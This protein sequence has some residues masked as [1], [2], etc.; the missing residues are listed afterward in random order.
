ME[1][2]EQ[3]EEVKIIKKN[4]GNTLKTIIVALL[5]MLCGSGFYIYKSSIDNKI[6]QQ[7]ELKL[8]EERSGL[9]ANLV[10]Q[11]ADYDIAINDKS[12]ISAELE[13]ERTKVIQLI[14]QVKNAKGNL[15]VLLQYKQKYVALESKMKELMLQNE[16]LKKKN[17]T[18]TTERDSTVAVLGVSKK[19][20]EDLVTQNT[21]LS[22][23]II[24]ASKLSVI[25]LKAGAFKLKNSGKQIETDKA[26]SADMIKILYSVAKNPVAKAGERYYYIQVIDSKNNVIGDRKTQT[27]GAKVLTFSVKSR[28][29]YQNETVNA[30]EDIL[31]KDLEKGTYFINVFDEGVL[32]ADTSFVLR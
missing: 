21:E 19:Q 23:T 1:I 3:K 20:N 15:N 4:D 7:N 10:K 24:K 13:A 17:I 16:E 27:F 2:Q 12:A 6:A 25:G 28:V 22:K 30:L 9:I 11:K 32:I 26:S 31:S 5:L 8:V 18:L 29:N 14:E